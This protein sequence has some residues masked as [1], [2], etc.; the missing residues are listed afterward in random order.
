VTASVKEIPVYGPNGKETQRIKVSGK[1]VEGNPLR[2]LLT[3]VVLMYQANRRQGTH[4]TK[5]RGEVSGGG[6]KPWR[7]KGTGRA[8]VG[9]IRSPLWRHGGTTFGPHPRDYRKEIP[10]AFRS[11]ALWLGLQAK[12]RDNEIVVVK[13][14][15]LGKP[16]T[17]ELASFL[18]VLPVKGKTLLVVE[19]MSLPL[20]RS[21]RNIPRLVVRARKDINALEMLRHRSLVIEQTAFENLMKEAES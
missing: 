1:L 15:S 9:S 6:R 12:V 17:G 18:R 14:I 11:Q 3:Q 13:P 7:Q 10:Q 8:R 20:Q 4:A 5:T 21:A 19:K 16:K 2:P